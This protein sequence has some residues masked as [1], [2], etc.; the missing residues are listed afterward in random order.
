MK[1]T[2]NQLIKLIKESMQQPPGRS[3]QF[4]KI[5]TLID[6]SIDESD[7]NNA[8][9]F[10]DSLSSV[11]PNEE[12]LL[13]KI[14]LAL[15][16]ENY[17]D[18]PDLVYEVMGAENNFWE[19]DDIGTDFL[20]RVMFKYVGDFVGTKNNFANTRSIF[21]DFN[22][23]YGKNISY[24]IGAQ[25]SNAPGSKLMLGK[26][27]EMFI[28]GKKYLEENLNVSEHDWFGFYVHVDVGKIKAGLNTNPAFELTYHPYESKASITVGRQSKLRTYSRA[29]DPYTDENVFVYIK[30]DNTK[31]NS[32]W[33]VFSSLDYIDNGFLNGLELFS[34]LE[35]AFPESDNLF[36]L[37][38]NYEN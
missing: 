31:D 9:M 2:R 6:G 21:N 18:I 16:S 19:P 14:D 22:Q 29:F 23:K 25:S 27:A 3:P 20:G 7:L 35:E 12:T 15:K 33:E 38:N 37:L 32:N 24:A 11:L 4:E 28:M 34:F 8:E 1:L 17:K 30:N 5:K 10:I 26:T 36:K 13:L